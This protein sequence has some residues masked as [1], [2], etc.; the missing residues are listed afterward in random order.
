[1]RLKSYFV[2]TMEE[3]LQTAKVEL[4]EDAM[5]V[6][7]KRLDSPPGSR[8]RLEVI[9]AAP[10]TPP[11]PPKVA[12]VPVPGNAIA[13]LRRFRGELTAL[14]DALNRKP[15]TARLEPLTPAGPQ[16][17]A[18]RGRL[19]LSEV[20]VP[21]IDETL[22]RCRPVIEGLVLRGVTGFGDT[23]RSVLPLL[24]ADWPHVLHREGGA[25]RVMALAGPA[26]AGK[27]S[28]IAKLAFRLGVSQGLPV[29][30]LSVDNLRVGASDHLAHICSLLGVPYLSLD[31][32]GA[33][34]AAVAASA[35]RGLILIDTPGFAAGDA[36]LLEETAGQLRRIEA[37]ECHLVLP[38]T[39][40]YSELQNRFQQYSAF[41]PSRLLFTRLDETE[42]FGPAWALARES[43]VPV[44][45]LS[46]G[47]GIPDDLEAAESS[48][49]AA[50]VLGQ[51]AYVTANTQ[52][53]Q[54]PNLASAAKAGAARI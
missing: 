22:Q 26:G 29:S 19:L 24:A 39:M 48:R 44:D 23:E 40:R 10:S 27:S 25:P 51:G 41:A 36:D 11:P 37:A 49:F 21:L 20:P 15:D 17:E 12:S 16:L 4:G 2:H 30:V 1:M 5:L 53:Q 34:S 38:A 35:Q 6:D 3:A 42:F 45:W 52:T 31:Y 43:R 54:T 18:L 28:A 50:A 9:F 8:A 46:T 13:G 33:L 14:L 47:P 7:S 32:S